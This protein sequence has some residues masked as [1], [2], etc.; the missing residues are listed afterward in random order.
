MDPGCKTPLIQVDLDN[1]IKWNEGHFGRIKAEFKSRLGVAINELKNLCLFGC[2]DGGAGGSS[3]SLE[4]AYIAI[5]GI[6]CEVTD[7]TDGVCGT[8]HSQRAIHANSWDAYVC[9]GV[10][11]L[12]EVLGNMR[13]VKTNPEATHIAREQFVT[14]YQNDDLV[15]SLLKIYNTSH[16][17]TSLQ[18]L[19]TLLLT[20]VFDVIVQLHHNQ[21]FINAF[22]N[23]NNKALVVLQLM[24][25]V[26]NDHQ[27]LM[28]GRRGTLLHITTCTNWLHKYDNTLDWIQHVVHIL[29]YVHQQIPVGFVGCSTNPQESRAYN[30]YT[31]TKTVVDNIVKQLQIPN[32]EENFST[33]PF[34]A[35]TVMNN[36]HGGAVKQYIIYAGRRYRV[37]WDSKRTRYILLKGGVKLYLSK[38]PKS[39]IKPCIG[40]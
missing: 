17:A 15:S 34:A 21:K 28:K 30:L 10:Q 2:L 4:A 14:D 38:I 9:N 35:A 32:A 22:Q 39:Q 7:K 3:V 6:M 12:Q 40:H 27:I 1:G 8:V 24:G 26:I 37:R 25:G 36:T 33:R 5:S 29:N 16:D 23:S 11:R 31:I 20:P 13:F 19:H 18:V